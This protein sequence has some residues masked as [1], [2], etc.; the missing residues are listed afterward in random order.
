[1]T[2]S[3]LL[4]RGSRI[5]RRISHC[6]VCPNCSPIC[7]EPCLHH[8]GQTCLTLQEEL[9]Q[10]SYHKKSNTLY[11]RA[12]KSYWLNCIAPRSPAMETGSLQCNAGPHD[13]QKQVGW[14]WGTWLLEHNCQEGFPGC[15]FGRG[16]GPPIV[17]N[18]P[19]PP[20]QNRTKV[21]SIHLLDFYSQPLKRVTGNLC[22]SALGGLLFNFEGRVSP[23]TYSD[24][25]DVPICS[26]NWV[27]IAKIQSSHRILKCLPD[28][29]LDTAETKPLNNKT[30]W[31]IYFLAVLASAIHCR[32]LIS[33]IIIW[34]WHYWCL[35]A[36]FSIIE[37]TWDIAM[38]LSPV[39]KKDEN[40]VKC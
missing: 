1:M 14:G 25:W 37:K 9:K 6:S 3:P 2:P 20:S 23:I 30:K 40:P 11:Q 13:F 24:L 8:R 7:G 39:E 38:F 5:G 4:Y 21:P 35:I 12:C 31:I 19:R 28:M 36:Q 22:P 16:C 27:T 18:A 17:C 15:L 34:W 10:C 32:L 29:R 26:S 33:Y